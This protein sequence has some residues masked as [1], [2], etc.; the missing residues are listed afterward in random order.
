MFRILLLF[1]ITLSYAQTVSLA[2]A[3]KA[4]LSANWSEAGKLFN[5]VGPQLDKSKQS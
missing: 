1:I 3:Q 5:T 2:D 4:Y